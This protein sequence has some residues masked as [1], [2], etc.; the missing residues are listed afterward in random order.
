MYLWHPTLLLFGA[1]YY[2][3][4]ETLLL[5]QQMTNDIRE[6]QASTHFKPI[7]DKK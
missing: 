6:F 1:K 3:P 5:M 2:I 4:I 7:V